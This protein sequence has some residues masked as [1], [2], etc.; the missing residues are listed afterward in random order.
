MVCICRCVLGSVI[1]ILL[2]SLLTIPVCVF[3]LAVLPAL[4]PSL[5]YVLAGL[6][7]V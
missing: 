3:F 5:D 4:F 6:L 7:F 1:V 2:F